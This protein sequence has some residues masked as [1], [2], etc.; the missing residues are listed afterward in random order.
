MTDDP[1]LWTYINLDTISAPEIA[2]KAFRRAKEYP[3]RIRYCAYTEL[4]MNCLAF[5]MNRVEELETSFSI[6]LFRAL[7]RTSAPKLKRFVMEFLN[8]NMV[9]YLPHLFDRNHPVLTDLTMINCCLALVG[10]NYRGLTKLDLRF[11]GPLILLRQDE[12]YLC[13]FRGCPGL[14]ELRLE[15]INLYREYE[16]YAN[17]IPLT[18]LRHMHLVL[19]IRDLKYIFALISAP[20]T[21]QLFIRTYNA[22]AL[23]DGILAALTTPGLPSLV[24]LTETR[25]VDADQAKHSI[26]AYRDAYVLQNRVLSYAT[27]THDLSTQFFGTSD[28]LITFAN[29]QPLP[30]LTRLRARDIKPESIVTLLKRCPSV[31]DVELIYRRGGVGDIAVMPAI[32]DALR[33]SQASTDS[34]NFLRNLRSL[35]LEKVFIDIDTLFNLV[36][37]RRACP[38]LRCI[39]MHSCQGDLPVQEMTDVLRGEFREVRWT[40]RSLVGAD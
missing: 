8:S 39:S 34:S 31:T 4:R 23:R 24:C 13:I 26:S 20:P 7:S 6:P 14:E 40:Q 30:N 27:T 33:R 35:S 17:T 11:Y 22:S 10:S 2:S 16:T 32:M 21:L 15:N 18:R 9:T 25:Y 19:D 3:L 29:L 37:L 36:E 38:E 5:E 28:D 1:F 12:D